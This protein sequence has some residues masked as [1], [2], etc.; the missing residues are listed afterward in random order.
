MTREV[1]KVPNE[2]LLMLELKFGFPT[3]RSLTSSSTWH[4]TVET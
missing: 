1:F 3:L 4:R 2:P